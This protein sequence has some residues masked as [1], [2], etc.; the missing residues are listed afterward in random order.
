MD[1]TIYMFVFS[2]VKQE[3]DNQQ[4]TVTTGDHTTSLNGND[5][6]NQRAVLRSI[7]S[8][9]IAETSRL[10]QKVRK[11]M[12]KLHIWEGYLVVKKSYTAVSFSYLT[13]P[14]ELQKSFS[15]G[16]ALSG[17]LRGG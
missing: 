5:L 10:G 1:C 8:T 4:R 14:L 3:L 12:A 7:C 9:G 2:Y 6:V 16:C 11:V 17:Q 13:P 15:T